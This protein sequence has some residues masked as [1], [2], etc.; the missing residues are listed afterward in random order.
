MVTRFLSIVM[1]IVFLAAPVSAKE[2]LFDKDDAQFLVDS[3]REVVDIFERRDETSF[4]AAQRTSLAES[5]RA[6]YCIGVLQQ[7]SKSARSSYCNYTRS[8]WF[9]MAKAIASVSTPEK[10]LS[11]TSI[12]SL[13]K[14]A[15]CER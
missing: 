6:G 7:Y 1:V 14:E 3:C 4:L 11:H 12:N 15:Y 5:M 9:E 2:A 13:L 8:N 10:K